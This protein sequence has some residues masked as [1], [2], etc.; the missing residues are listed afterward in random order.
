[1]SDAS[2]ANREAVA[3]EVRALMGRRRVSGTRLAKA[4][5]M[6]Q[7]ALSRRL[8]GEHPFDIDELFAVAEHFGVA[9]T[10]LF[11]RPKSGCVTA[12]DVERPAEAVGGGRRL[13]ALAGSSL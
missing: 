4:L 6:S 1:M 8:N 9:I 5:G 2:T 7:S 10:A 13:V 3:E 12:D 11:G